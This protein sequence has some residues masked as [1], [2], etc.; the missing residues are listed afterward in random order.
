M[1]EQFIKLINQLRI[2]NKISLTDSHTKVLSDYLITNGA[3]ICKKPTPEI[4]LKVIEL[5]NKG[6]KVADIA[7]KLCYSERQIYRY[8]AKVR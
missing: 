7:K 1:R 4:V 8:L 2:D 5:R 6:Y 3:V